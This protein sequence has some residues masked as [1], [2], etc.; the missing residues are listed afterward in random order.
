[1][2]ID[3]FQGVADENKDKY[4]VLVRKYRA[5]KAL[6]YSVFH[7]WQDMGF[8]TRQLSFGDIVVP[9]DARYAPYTVV[10]DPHL[11]PLTD[12]DI[13]DLMSTVEQYYHEFPVGRNGSLSYVRQGKD[14]LEITAKEK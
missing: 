13:K 3:E 9:P 12:E 1:M 10:R 7:A 11:E 2:T 5:L 8:G 6:G 14:Q 4:E